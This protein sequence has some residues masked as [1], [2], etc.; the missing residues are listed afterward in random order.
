MVNLSVACVNS[1]V[2]V[3]V[4][5]R[6][7]SCLKGCVEVGTSLA[8]ALS[9]SGARMG[10][11]ANGVLVADG[12]ALTATMTTLR[13]YVPALTVSDTLGLLGSTSLGLLG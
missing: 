11:A 2:S 7:S 3:L 4:A 13:V 9:R 5:Q 12:P 1:E 8:A 10:L 6:E